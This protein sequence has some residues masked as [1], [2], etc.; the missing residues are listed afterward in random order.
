MTVRMAILLVLKS[1]RTTR[2][3]SRWLVMGLLGVALWPATVTRGSWINLGRHKQLFIDDFIISSSQGLS[4]RLQ[5]PTKWVGNP[6]LPAV[7]KDQ[8]LWE[9]D[10]DIYFPSVI[11][12]HEAGCFKMWYGLWERNKRDEDSVLAY[13]TSLDGI[14]WRKPYLG[15]FN[16][17]ATGK[18][19]LVLDHNGLCCGVFKDIRERDPAKR[20]KM[21]FMCSD[22]YKVC[23]AYSSN[24]LNWKYYSG[25]AAVISQFP[26]GLFSDSH[27]VAY[28]DEKLNKY[29]AILRQR[30]GKGKERHKTPAQSESDDFVHWTPP[31][32]LLYPG[33]GDGKYRN[34]YN[35]EVMQYGGIHLGFTTVF[36]HGSEED[37]PFDLGG[38]QLVY[39]RDGQ[40]WERWKGKVFLPYSDQPG[41]FDWGMVYVAQ[42][43]LVVGDEIYIYYA[44]HGHDHR[45]HLPTGVNQVRGGVG[46]AKLRL[47][48]FV[49]IEPTVPKGQGSLITKPFLLQG[50]ELLINAIAPEGQLMVEILDVHHRPLKNFNRKRCDPFSSNRVRHKV[51][52]RG[53]SSLKK[54]QGKIIRLKFYLVAA[55][56]YAFEFQ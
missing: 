32:P 22:S 24:G 37:Q 17:R 5:E 15:I 28:W 3:V 20:Y 13:A 18:N 50:K 52:W 46:L 10:M 40:H 19:N 42:A 27:M 16:Y 1:T 44:G 6:V 31:R 51:S 11:F 4:R 29:V 25:G 2:L 38:V 41:D 7:L 21:L 12:D 39:S 36:A 26:D 9:S 33:D 35:M 53:R 34:F 8:P 30:S 23:A 14:V 48:G 43:P 56:L 45:H 47:D 49:S 54:L 55:R